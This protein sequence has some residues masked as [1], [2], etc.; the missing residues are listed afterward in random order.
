MALDKDVRGLKTGLLVGFSLLL[1]QLALGPLYW[2]SLSWYSPLL[3]NAVNTTFSPI[4]GVKLIAVAAL[5]A[6]GYLSL[7]AA[8][9][10]VISSYVKWLGSLAL[11]TVAMGEILND[12]SRYPNIVFA[13]NKALPAELFANFYIDVP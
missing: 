2:L 12:G 7:K 10:G 4:F 8:K 3:F 1:A 11:F 5:L 9:S 13:G 6:L